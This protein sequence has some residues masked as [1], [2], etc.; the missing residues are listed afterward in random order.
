MSF[1]DRDQH[2]REHGNDD[3]VCTQCEQYPA[4]AGGLCE[5]CRLFREYRRVKVTH[6]CS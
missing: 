6:G 5:R 1:P 2:E 4:E 3:L